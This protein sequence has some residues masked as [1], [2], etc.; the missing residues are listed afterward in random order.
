MTTPEKIEEMVRK[1]IGFS[2][3]GAKITENSQPLDLGP[4][5]RILRCYGRI[6]TS[7]GT[8]KP[9]STLIDMLFSKMRSEKVLLIAHQKE[10]ALKDLLVTAPDLISSAF[11]KNSIE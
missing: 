10:Y 5:F 8:E 7:I 9:L 1:G 3:F 4:F 6:M 11:S 2:K